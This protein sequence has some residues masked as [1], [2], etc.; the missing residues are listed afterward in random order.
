MALNL[1]LQGLCQ[2]HPCI[3][4][5]VLKSSQLNIILIIITDP[6]PFSSK[7]VKDSFVGSTTVPGLQE[8]Y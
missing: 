3:Q 2:E 5:R 7:N 4:N 6:L 1:E 8:I